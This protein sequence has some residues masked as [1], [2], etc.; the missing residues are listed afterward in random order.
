[1]TKAN[2]F[3]IKE[4]TKQEMQPITV[5]GVTTNITDKWFPPP[6]PLIVKDIS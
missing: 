5:S 6:P 2:N 4:K 3:S 1:M